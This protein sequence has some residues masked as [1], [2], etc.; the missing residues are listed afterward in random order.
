[1]DLATVLGIVLAGFSVIGGFILEGGHLDSIIQ[2]TAAIIV[3]GGTF[4]CVMVA[5]PADQLKLAMTGAIEVFK[6][7]SVEYATA[8][9]QIV[10][11]AQK[12]R[13]EGVVSLEADAEELTDPFFKKALNMAV[14]GSE[15]RVIRDAM[16]IEMEKMEH[17]GML[18]SKAWEQ[19]GAFA[20][21]I[22]ILG[23]VLGLIH[24]MGN[25]S[26]PEKL[27][28]GIAVAFVATVYGVGVANIFMFPFSVKLKERAHREMV[29]YELIITGVCAIV[30]GE[31]PRLIEQKLKGFVPDHGG[32][33]HDGDE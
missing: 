24:V 29:L 28:A 21:T 7:H 17:H 26:D 27:G 10:D 4:A 30:D 25:I 12:A 32:A 13:R 31:N 2:G 1:M 6:G 11:F 9:Q 8:V 5:C 19:A 16:D 3:F 14:D 23:A 33:D 15:S 20:P 18:G 22:G